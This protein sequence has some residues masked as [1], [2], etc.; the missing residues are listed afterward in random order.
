LSDLHDGRIY[1]NASAPLPG[2]SSEAAPNLPAEDATTLEAMV[3]SLGEY[4]DA[5]SLQPVKVHQ[6]KINGA[7]AIDSLQPQESE[8]HDLVLRVFRCLIADLCEQFKGGHPG[9]V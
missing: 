3:P 9:S 6:S 5:L 7:Y 8:K 2:G 4:E 1:F